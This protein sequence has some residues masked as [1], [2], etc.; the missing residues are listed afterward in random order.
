MITPTQKTEWLLSHINTDGY[1]N[2]SDKSTDTEKLQFIAN[3]LKS[4]A[5]YQ[6]NI[7]RFNSNNQQIIA[8][9]LMGLPSYLN[10]PFSNY[11]ILQ[12]ATS[13]E[14][15]I[16]TEKKQDNFVNNYWGGVAMIILIAFRK[17]HIVF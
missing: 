16:S 12:L 6:H 7:K 13:W 11:D 14:Y 1:D 2:I 17:Y 8:D 5:Y 9:H 15:D 3:C 10:I 4:E